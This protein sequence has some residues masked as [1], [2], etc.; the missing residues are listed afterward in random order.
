MVLSIVMTR[1]VIHTHFYMYKCIYKHE[2]IIIQMIEH[3][4]A[5]IIY[6]Q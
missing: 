5:N 6:M 1:S 2:T 4:H 3:K